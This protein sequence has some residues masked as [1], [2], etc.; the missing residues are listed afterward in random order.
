[1][2]MNVDQP[3]IL[4]ELMVKIHF[5]MGLLP[6]LILSKLVSNYNL[7]LI[8][9]I[10]MVMHRIC[11]AAEMAIFSNHHSHTFTRGNI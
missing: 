2:P 11:T 9:I 10:L 7:I 1:M 5:I 6:K 3:I 4:K 8:L